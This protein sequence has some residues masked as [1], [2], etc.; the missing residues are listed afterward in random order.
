[1]D[2]INVSENVWS[3]YEKLMIFVKKEKMGGAWVA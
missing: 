3:K 1:M 2:M